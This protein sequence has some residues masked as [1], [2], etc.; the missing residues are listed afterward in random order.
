[1]FCDRFDFRQSSR[2]APSLILVV[3]TNR[4]CLVNCSHHLI[5][6]RSVSSI[7]SL[8]NH[9]NITPNGTPYIVPFHNI[10]SRA[11]VR[12]VDFFPSDLADFAVPCPKSSEYDILS[13]VGSNGSDTES[14][15]GGQNESSGLDDERGWEWRFGLVLEDAMGPRS[16]EKATVEVYVAGQDAECLLKLDAEEYVLP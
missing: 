10:N 14:A 11:T 9:S 12:V 15:L 6:P 8:D 16:E 2:V 7:I 13:D 1:V 4:Y 3:E 5:T